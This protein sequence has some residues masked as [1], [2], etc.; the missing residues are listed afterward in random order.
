MREILIGFD[1]AWT[2]RSKN[3]GAIAAYVFEPSKPAVFHPPRLATF[4]AAVQFVEDLTSK[5]DYLLIA[6]NQPTIV[7]NDAGSRPVDRVAASLV[8]RLKGGVHPARRDGMGVPM[9]G[10]IAPVWNFLAAVDAIQNPID[11]RTAAAGRFVIEVFPALALP[12][13]V[14][15]LWN[16]GRAARYNPA[17]SKFDPLDWPLV[18]SGLAAFARRLSAVDLADWAE[19]ESRRAVPRTVDQDR[20][21]AAICL[22][23]AQAWRHG[24]PDDT[25]LIGD[26]RT[27]YMATVVSE[28]TR[29]VLVEAAAK[30]GV[31]VDRAWK[32]A[33]TPAVPTSTP[34]R[35]TIDVIASP[36]RNL[37]AR[38]DRVALRAFLVECARSDIVVEYGQVATRFGQPW[39]RGSSSS[40]TSALDALGVEN[41]RAGE[42][43]LMCLAVNKATRQPGQKYFD[44]IGHGST[45]AAGQTSAHRREVDRCQRWPWA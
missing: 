22:A 36:I 13:I 1:S 31:A 25:L 9:F 17:A 10:D 41:T 34:P 29:S 28:Q 15:A 27:G 42:P 8:A 18:A 21:D 24:P 4:E 35:Q 14:P 20:L 23:I 38:V 32:R 5:D 33:T 39:S 30:C 6:V 7:P 2:N 3:P 37:S 11:A 44:T 40:L 26:E 43:L 16:R 45:D 12:A 19:T